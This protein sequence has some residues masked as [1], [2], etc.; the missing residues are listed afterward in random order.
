MH[1]NC[2]KTN[3]WFIYNSWKSN[4][5]VFSAPYVTNAKRKKEF[6]PD[7]QVLTTIFKLPSWT[8]LQKTNY[9]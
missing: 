9:P 2:L 5:V 7:F 4:A 8:T 1:R 3:R 6:C